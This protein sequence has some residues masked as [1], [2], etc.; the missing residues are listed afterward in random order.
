MSLKSSKENRPQKNK[1]LVS[2]DAVT[3]QMNT[4]LLCMLTSDMDPNH[5]KVPTH[6]NIGLDISRKRSLEVET[7]PVQPF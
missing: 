6:E 7:S 1:Y 4:G 3:E 5:R 2:W